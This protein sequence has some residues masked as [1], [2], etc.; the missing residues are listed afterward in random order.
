MLS[1][2][3]LTKD[4]LGVKE[5]VAEGRRMSKEGGEWGVSKR[6]LGLLSYLS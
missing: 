6:G 1:L 3:C 4:V 5:G 2:P